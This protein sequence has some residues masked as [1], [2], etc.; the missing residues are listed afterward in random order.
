MQFEWDEAKRLSNIRRHGIDFVEVPPLFDDD[1]V[2]VEDTRITYSEQRFVTLGLLK[3]RVLVV[4]H[5]ERG[6]KIRLISARKA[7]KYEKDSYFE[8]I[9][10][11]LE[12]RRRAKR[13]RY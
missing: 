13:R 11:R 4:V 7:T 12:T 5:T 3:G 2:T 10:D 6:D 8:Q 9:H 1:T